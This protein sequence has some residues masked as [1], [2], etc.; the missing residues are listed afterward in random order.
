ML[1]LLGILKSL[2]SKKVLGVAIIPVAIIAFALWKGKAWQG[3]AIKYLPVK[4]EKAVKVDKSDPLWLRK[5]CEAEIKN[6]PQPPFKNKGLDGDVH[7]LSIPD[8]YLKDIIPKDKWYP[9]KNC[10]LWYKYDPKEA[11]PSVAVEYIFDIRASNAFQ[12]NVD[13]LISEAIAK[14][15]KKISPFDDKAA[16]R[17]LYIYK[18]FPLVFTR[19]KADTGTTELVVFTWGANNFFVKL[20]VYEK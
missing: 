18:G 19:E 9:A 20:T 17:P 10:S 3:I 8:V 5:Y 1:G 6:L 7:F 13:R 11:Y 15:W 16:G 14:N 12:E 2:L 4:Q